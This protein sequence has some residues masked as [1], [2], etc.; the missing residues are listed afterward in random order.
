MP[1]SVRL[2]AE[3]QQRIDELA[4]R[5]HRS[6][7]FYLREAIDRGLPQVER[8]YD[9][10][11][12]SD[13]VRDKSA[14]DTVSARETR[15]AAGVVARGLGLDERTHALL[16]ERAAKS[17][18]SFGAEVREILDAAVDPPQENILLELRAAMRAVGGVDLPTHPRTDAP[19]PV[20]LS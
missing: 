11:P 13:D 18:R 10:A 2:S 16:R 14:A 7:S 8:E 9:P 20:D 17:G 19:R 1:T 15:E 3:T 6:A 12:R 5:T 4:R